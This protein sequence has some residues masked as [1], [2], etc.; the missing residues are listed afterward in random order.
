MWAILVTVS[1]LLEKTAYSLIAEEEICVFMFS[2]PRFPSLM[3][4]QLLKNS[5]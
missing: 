1:H 5:I 4:P 2:I 3:E